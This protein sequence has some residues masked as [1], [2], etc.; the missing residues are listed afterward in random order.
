M[1]IRAA[2]KK[3]LGLDDAMVD[4][5]LEDTLIDPRPVLEPILEPIVDELAVLRDYLVG[6]LSVEPKCCLLMGMSAGA[7]YFAAIAEE[8]AHLTV[9][10][11]NLFE[12]L[13]PT[14]HTFVGEGAAIEGG[15]ANAFIGALGAALAMVGEEG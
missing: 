5:V 1:A 10:A 3:E 9:V 8:R 13:S 6:K 2:L 4:A 12:G 11:P 14:E 7:K 15:A